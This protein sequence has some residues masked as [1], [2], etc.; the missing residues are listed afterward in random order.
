CASSTSTGSRTLV[1]LRVRGRERGRDV[2]VL[3]VPVTHVVVEVED[4]V[5]SVE[6]VCNE[7]RATAPD[8]E[9]ARV[10]S[11]LPGDPFPPVEEVAEHDRRAI[12]R[13]TSDLELESEPVDVGGVELTND[14]DVLGCFIP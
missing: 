9:E 8:I 12:T 14:L 6:P 10:G 4:E 2:V 13:A 5:V 1:E 11:R 7:R 3:L